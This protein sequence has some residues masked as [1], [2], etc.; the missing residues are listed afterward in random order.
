MRTSRIAFP[1]AGPALTASLLAVS[2]TGTAQAQSL[3]APARSQISVDHAHSGAH[4]GTANENEPRY[5][6]SLTKLL[7]AD[8]VFENGS[9]ADKDKASR[10]IRNSDD[11]LASELA[12]KYPDAISTISSRY[13][14]NSAVP[15]DSWGNWKFSSNDWSRYLSAKLREDPTG[16][17][18]LLSAMR[19]S[20]TVAAD[21]YNQRFGVALLPGVEGWKSGWS[22]DRSTFH[23][24]VGF[25][26]GWTVAVQT[27]GTRG[28]LNRDLTDV[29]DRV[30]PPT[31]DAAP[32]TTNWPARAVAQGAVDD[33][34]AWVNQVAPGVQV[35]SPSMDAVPEYIPLPD[36]I[37]GALP[38]S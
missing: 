6:L 22:D 1:V 27:N 2:L 5:S 28:A 7:I 9:A 32:G 15:A 20:R 10:M 13:N 12:G 3:D 36:V 21:G 38:S 37:A 11:A 30:G 31:P 24:S 29:L 34:T 23:A 17:G 33:V 25:G 16:T 18:P 8:Y 26:G 14:M 35:E 19:Q 4:L